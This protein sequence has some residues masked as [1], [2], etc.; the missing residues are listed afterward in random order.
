VHASLFRTVSLLVVALALATCG[1]KP[2]QQPRPAPPP[3]VTKA[4][5]K[6]IPKAKPDDPPPG[7]AEHDKALAEQFA[8]Y[9]DTYSNRGLELSPDGKLLLFLS[10]RGGGSY[11]LYVAPADKP[12]AEPTPIAKAKDAVSD[13]RF[14]ADGLGILFTRDKDR[15]ENSQIYKAS[16]DGKEIVPLTKAPERFH[17]LPRA[18]PDWT[19]VVYIRG[20]HKT[21]GVRLVTQPLEGS[22]AKTVLQTKGFHFLTDVSP[23]GKTALVFQLL[24]MSRSVLYAVDLATG[25]KTQLA[26]SKGATAHAHSSAYSSDGK[27]VYVVTDEGGARAVLRRIDATTGA[28]QATFAD[29]EAE[30]A[31]VQASRATPLVAALLDYGSHTTVKLLDAATLKE[32]AKVKLPL[33]SISMGQFTADGKGLVITVSTPSAPTDV[34]LLATGN[35]RAKPLRSEKRPAAKKIVQVK[36]K[37]ERVPTFDSLKVPVN[38]YLPARLPAAH[39]LPVIVSVHGGPAAA[40]SIRWNPML[41]FWVSRGFAVVEPNVRGSTGF[42]KEYEKADNGPRRLDAVKDLGA[43][44]DWVRSQK[45]AD[46]ERLVVH[47]GSYGG[48]MT[49]MA[50]GHQPEKWRAGIGLVGVVNLRTFLRTTTG[51]IRMA[52][53]EEFGELP[54]DGSFLDSVSPIAAVARMRAPL[55]VYQGANDPRVPRS[56]QDQLVRA[57]RKRKVP[58]EY[59]VADD[60]GH[61]L[62]QRENKLAFASRSIRFLSQH[63]DLPGLPDACKVQAASA[64]SEEKPK[65]APAAEE[66]KAAKGA[67]KKAEKK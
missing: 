44:N 65:A 54:K 6:K 39:K 59:V 51:A 43:V 12:A 22:K 52:F 24:S 31:D 61:S 33:G 14:T 55:F 60:E 2:P 37:V 5:R 18:L 49:Y 28:T 3:K 35:G 9:N 36:S 38:V 30:V 19:S 7:C 53:V 50:L 46:T 56:E 10:D 11:Q 15:N 17:F 23:D 48:Y 16:L 13:A 32:K 66:P 34:F 42:G 29:A 27:S 67:K 40:S 57:L 26:P 4:P 21:G 20:V 45:W 25:K 41:M 58:V 8:V 62:S 1:S 64:Q 47:G 63:L